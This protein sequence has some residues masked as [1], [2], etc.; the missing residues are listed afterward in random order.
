MKI[1]FFEIKPEEKVFFEEAL[2][3]HELFFFEETINS[4]LSVMQSYDVVSVFV[5]S[6]ISDEILEKLPRVKYLQ[7][8]STGYDHIKCRLLY[9]RGLLLSNVAGY[10]GPAVA[11]FSFSLLLNMT[12]LAYVA[13]ERTKNDDLRYDDLKGVELYGKTIGILGLGTIGTQMARIAHGLGMKIVAFSRTRKAIVDELKIDFCDLKKVLTQ[14]DIIMLALPLTPA[15]HHILNQNNIDLLKA[16]AIVVNT[17]RAELI[18]EIL[19]EKMDHRFGL[20]VIN[21]EKYIG[22]KNIIYTPHMAY[23]TEEAL[24]RIMQISLKNIEAF[25]AEKVLPNCLQLPCEKDYQ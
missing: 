1:A 24:G 20:D 11:E 19:Y 2:Q 10:G 13:I 22:Q 8:R 9:K 23:Y 16:D 3:V 15:T 4:A 25:L 14:S 7:T 17:A 6:I 18:E 12:R 21:N 5:H